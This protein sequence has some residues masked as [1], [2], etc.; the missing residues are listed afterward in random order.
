MLAA[1]RVNPAGPTWSLMMQR[2]IDQPVDEGDVLE[3]HRKL[4]RV[5]YHLSVYQHFAEGGDQPL[6]T[7]V[8]VEGHITPV[9]RL[10]LEELHH[11]RPELTLRLADGRTLDFLVASTNGA[12]RSTGR[13]LHTD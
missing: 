13:G 9:E 12:I 6:P 3:G 4:G 10:D 11:R 2:L 5:H 1:Q 8:D 7:Y